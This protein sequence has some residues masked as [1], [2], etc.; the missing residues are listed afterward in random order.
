MT[1]IITLPVDIS[2]SSS[3]TGTDTC[4]VAVLDTPNGTILQQMLNDDPSL[5]FKLVPNGCG[6]VKR[7]RQVCGTVI[8]QL[9]NIVLVSMDIFQCQHLFK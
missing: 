2:N 3:W 9:T 1:G 7:V 4:E 6:I 8:Y 5:E